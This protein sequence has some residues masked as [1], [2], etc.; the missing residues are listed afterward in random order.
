M[1][2]SIGQGSKQVWSINQHSADMLVVKMSRTEAATFGSK[3]AKWP[4]WTEPRHIK[5]E[6][7]LAIDLQQENKQKLSN[8]KES[9]PKVLEVFPQAL[10]RK[11][12]ST[13]YFPFPEFSQINLIH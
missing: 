2:K 8:D 1:Q 6:R 3:G 5:G 13:T 9:S 7:G 4:E 12:Q 10:C 11:W